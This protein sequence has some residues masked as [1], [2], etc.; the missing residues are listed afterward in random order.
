MGELAEHGFDD[1]PFDLFWSS[2]LVATA[3]T[4]FLLEL[5]DAARAI[6]RLLEPYRDQVAF[7]GLWVAA[8]IAHGLGVAAAT[9]RDPESAGYFR[10]SVK[11]AEQ[12]EAP[13]LR[14]RTLRFAALASETGRIAQVSA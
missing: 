6:H 11:L 2:I 12:L 14:A 8:P 7:S 13:I 10:Q 4:A 5:P 3:E 9:Y 1:L